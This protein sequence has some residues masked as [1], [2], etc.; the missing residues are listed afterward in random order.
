[1]EDLV[2]SFKTSQENE[3]IEVDE[4]ED[5]NIHI[6]NAAEFDT[7]KILD[8]FQKSGIFLNKITFPTCGENMKLE[9]NIS[10]ID[11]FIWRCSSKNPI[12]DH[13]I[14]VRSNY[15]YEGIKQTLPTIYFLTFKYFI[16]NVGVSN[17]Y[18][19]CR[20]FCKELKIPQPSKSFIIKLFRILL[21]RIKIVFYKDWR[22]SKL[23]TE[24]AENGI[25]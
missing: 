10:Y 15:I 2:D 11:K 23:A 3:G 8:Y 24:P 20:Q 17:S 19:K 12:H 9:R 21:N 13:K 16:D 4:S 1:M 14:N 18:F 22:L 5:N 25:P 7:K 6:Y